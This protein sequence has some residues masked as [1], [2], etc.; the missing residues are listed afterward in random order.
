MRSYAKFRNA[1]EVKKKHFKEQLNLAP[2]T[3]KISFTKALHP[4][5]KSVPGD[6]LKESNDIYKR[7]MIRS[8][9]VI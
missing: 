3:D 6:L 1:T 4:I 9:G 7:L 5:N 8:I 2:Y